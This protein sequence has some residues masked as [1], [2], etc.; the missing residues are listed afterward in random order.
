MTAQM[1]AEFCAILAADCSTIGDSLHCA[2]RRGKKWVDEL[3]AVA[4]SCAW[5]P[6]G[7]FYRSTYL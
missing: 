1:D 4:D 3:C 2:A 6:A 7:T 5:V